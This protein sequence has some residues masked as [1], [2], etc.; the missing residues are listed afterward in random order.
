MVTIDESEALNKDRIKRIQ[1][2]VGTLLY[3]ARAVDSTMLTAL[4]SL[5]SAQ[6]NG[7]V[8]TE[9]ATN[10]LL[11]YCATH[12]NAGIV[13]H[14]SEMRLRIHSDA[15]YLCEPKA[16][17]RAGGHFYLSNKQDINNGAVINISTIIKHVM[18]SAMESEIAAIFLNAREALPLRVLLEELGHH[19]EA[20]EIVTDNSTAHGMI[21]KTM[22]PRRSKSIDM[23]FH[24]L[25]CR[26]AQQQFR[27]LWAP[28]ATNLADYFTK[29]FS[30]AHHRTVRGRYVKDAPGVPTKYKA[31]LA[32]NSPFVLP[33]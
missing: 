12:P 3:Y 32:Q 24:W 18:A 8:E 31:R 13:Y 33:Q 2:V 28:G 14:A 16:R 17:S 21:N 22:T 29:H 27:I 9:R 10:Q 6:A 19:Q 5:A 1:E 7:T 4:S 23:R 11:D 26:E 20:T 25:K 15:S 30:P